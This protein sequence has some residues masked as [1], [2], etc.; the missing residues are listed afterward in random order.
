[1]RH[2]PLGGRRLVD[3]DKVAELGVDDIRRIHVAIV[4]AVNSGRIPIERID[5]AVSRVIFLK[6]RYQG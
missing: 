5:E 6:S 4:E 1:M 3:R 2:R